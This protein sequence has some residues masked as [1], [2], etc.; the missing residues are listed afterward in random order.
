MVFS[1]N[2]IFRMIVIVLNKIYSKYGHIHDWKYGNTEFSKYG[3]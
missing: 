2:N 1:S 3:S